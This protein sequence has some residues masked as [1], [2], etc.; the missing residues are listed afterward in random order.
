MNNVL[1]KKISINIHFNL[2]SIFY[3]YS[4]VNP[5]QKKSGDKKEK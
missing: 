5:E 4:G 1:L 3:T 2:R